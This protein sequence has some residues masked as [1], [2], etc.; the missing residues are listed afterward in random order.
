M[1]AIGL[2]IPLS[3]SSTWAVKSVMPLIVAAVPAGAFQTPRLLSVAAQTPAT[4]PHGPALKL[5]PV[6]SVITRLG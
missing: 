4:A 2:S 5:A 6:L 1:T 3:P